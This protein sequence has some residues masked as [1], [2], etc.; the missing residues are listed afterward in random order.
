[1]NSIQKQ[2]TE[3]KIWKLLRGYENIYKTEQPTFTYSTLSDSFLMK[4]ELLSKLPKE[5]ADKLLTIVK[6][7]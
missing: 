1:M 7:Y 6:P 2:E 5:I 3:E 4:K